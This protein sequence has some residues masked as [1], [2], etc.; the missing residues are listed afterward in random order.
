MRAFEDVRRPSKSLMS[1]AP[2]PG[3]FVFAFSLPLHCADT[4]TQTLQRTGSNAV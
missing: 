2:R 1:P 4:D 3:M